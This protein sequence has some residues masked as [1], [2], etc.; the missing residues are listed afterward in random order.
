[1]HFVLSLVVSSSLSDKNMHYYGLVFKFTIA[2][3]NVHF[4]TSGVHVRAYG[5]I[6]DI[7]H[8]RT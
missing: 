6:V 3:L 8:A 5:P 2:N 4:H 7:I 1:M